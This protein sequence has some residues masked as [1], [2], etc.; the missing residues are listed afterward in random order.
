LTNVGDLLSRVDQLTALSSALA[1]V[2][3]ATPG[4]ADLY[5]RLH[6]EADA[7]SHL[8][9]ELADELNERHELSAK[10]AWQATHDPLTGLSNRAH[11]IAAVETALAGARRNSLLVALLFVD[12]DGFK[13]INDVHGHA[14]GDI[15]LAEVA[16]RLRATV[17]ADALAARLGGDEFVVVLEGLSDLTEAVRLGQR[18][19][20]EIEVPMTTDTGTVM[21]LSASVGV[22]ATAAGALD[23]MSL[24]P[25]LRC[26]GQRPAAEGEWRSSTPRCRR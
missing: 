7:V 4:I 21:R 18:L 23:A 16:R 25:T 26:I 20:D 19:I 17:R 11:A 6:H 2:A 10:L 3:R 14:V 12:L 9:A 5:D 13:A 22:S 1:E 24:L 15:V 8:A